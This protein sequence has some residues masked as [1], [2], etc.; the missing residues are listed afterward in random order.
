MQSDQCGFCKH[1]IVGFICFAFDRI[2]DEILEGKSHDTVIEGQNGDY[3]FEP[4][5]E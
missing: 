1:R 5:E 2:P 4:M 3:V